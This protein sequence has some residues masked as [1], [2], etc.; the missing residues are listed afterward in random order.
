MARPG[1]PDDDDLIVEL[2]DRNDDFAPREDEKV[3]AF[4]PPPALASTVPEDDEDDEDRSELSRSV[5]DARQKAEQVD[6][7]PDIDHDLY[8]RVTAAE[9]SLRQ[10]R[11]NAIWGQAQA[12]A[13]MA[14]TK[15]NG[16]RVALDTLNDR[17][18]AAMDGLAQA[19]ESG[20]IRAETQIKD[21]ID[22][23]RKLKSEIQAGLQQAP[24]RDSILA[25]GRQRAQAAM[26]QE[27]GGKKIGS[28]IQ[29][30][31]PLAE[32]FAQVNG[33][34]KVNGKANRDV[35]N[36]ANALTR[37][38][39][40]PNERSFYA[41]LAKRVQ[42]ANPALKVSALQAGKK[43]PSRAGGRSPVAPSRSSSG[44]VTMVN[45]KVNYK[46]S[47]QEQRTMERHKL[48]PKNPKHQKAWARVRM[49]SAKREQAASQGR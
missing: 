23:M 5:D 46:L 9:E 42:T 43:A 31:H 44:Q 16:A 39:Y 33:W 36:F 47:A 49:T 25:E 3:E 10:E 22:E 34:M 18:S 12:Y 48:D 20:D 38:G 37:E 26:A 32:Q 14:D 28:G 7:A 1:A 45:G 19:R 11:A 30:R 2:E 24:T 15:I 13:E 21:G 4:V 17:L 41:E 35:I 40:N 8:E 29:A 27:Q 6:D